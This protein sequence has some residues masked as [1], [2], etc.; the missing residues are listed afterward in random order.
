M[1][2]TYML[3]TYIRKAKTGEVGQLLGKKKK[4][5]P[6]QNCLLETLAPANE[7]TYI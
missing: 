4:I 1:Q 7:E 2:H 3:H 6:F 5:F